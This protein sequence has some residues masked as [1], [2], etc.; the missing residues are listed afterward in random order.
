MEMNGSY[1]VEA[2]LILPI[3]FC[4]VLGILQYGFC[5]HDQF[6]MKSLAYNVAVKDISDREWQNGTLVKYSDKMLEEYCNKQT[7]LHFIMADDI[8]V[9]FNRDNQW[10]TILMQGRIYL[11]DFMKLY[12]SSDMERLKVKWKVQQ[13]NAADFVRRSYVAVEKI[14]K[15]WIEN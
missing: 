13:N 11:P 12:W 9:S 8:S 5:L 7:E 14:K 6:V 1:T 10:S 2:A 4:M 3:V 15:L